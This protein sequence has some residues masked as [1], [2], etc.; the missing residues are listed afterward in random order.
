MHNLNFR[1]I[2]FQT[3]RKDE[4]SRR[5]VLILRKY[6]YFT[7]FLMAFGFLYDFGQFIVFCFKPFNILASHVIGDAV[8]GVIL[9]VPELA[10]LFELHNMVKSMQMSPSF[11]A[12]A[13]NKINSYLK[14]NLFL[15]ICGIPLCFLVVYLEPLRR[16]S[17]IIWGIFNLLLSV[18]A[19]SILSKRD[20]VASD[21]KRLRGLEVGGVAEIS[22]RAKSTSDLE[23]SF[24]GRKP[25]S[26]TET[27]QTKE[28]QFLDQSHTM[29]ITTTLDQSGRENLE[30]SQQSR[31]P[32]EMNTPSTV[33]T[34]LSTNS[35]NS[36]YQQIQPKDDVEEN[37]VT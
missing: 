10:L 11:Y 30:P 26:P 32:V 24:S 3:K 2:L 36:E 14:M 18:N 12:E 5:L 19:Y 20:T 6:K 27:G 15:S 1:N 31:T 7:Y 28:N 21:E 13:L 34:T 33:K 37:Y 22:A 4:N 35:G 8:I 9:L 17:Y 29:M 25:R 23:L 16:N